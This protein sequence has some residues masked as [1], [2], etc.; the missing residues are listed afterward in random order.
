[1]SNRSG[2]LSPPRFGDRA[3]HCESI[4]TS[5]HW[6]YR[7][8]IGRGAG[9]AAARSF[10]RKF[11]MYF[12]SLSESRRDGAGLAKGELSGVKVKTPEVVQS[13]RRMMGKS[14][15]PKSKQPRSRQQPNF[16]RHS[17]TLHAKCSNTHRKKGSI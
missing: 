4:G 10:S 15:S 3:S 9:Q 6:R 11:P 14:S 8:A 2:T 16:S 5:R 17:E 13:G 1:M 7:R 12:L